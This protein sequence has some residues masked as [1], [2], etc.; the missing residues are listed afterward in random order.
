MF[1]SSINKIYFQ[2]Y[3]P[4]LFDGKTNEKIY[5]EIVKDYIIEI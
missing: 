4:S 5:R 2:D 1:D 3:A